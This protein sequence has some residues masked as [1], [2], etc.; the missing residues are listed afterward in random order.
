MIY[1]A[2]ILTE[3]NTHPYNCKE[4]TLKVY[5]GIAYRVEIDFPPGCAGLLIVQIYYHN[6]QVWP[7]TPGAVFHGQDR[8]ISF[9]DEFPIT[10]AP[11]EFIIKTANADQVFH[12]A[13]QVRIGV[14]PFP[15]VN[16]RGFA[17]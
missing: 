1:V 8:H 16:V 15:K 4:T 7:T 6:F 12:H 5:K 14:K 11:Y 10:S 3:R 13:V 9:D 17:P 2:D